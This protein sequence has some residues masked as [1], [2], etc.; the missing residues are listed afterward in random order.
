M[1]HAY[2]ATTRDIQVSVRT[3]FLPDQSKPEEG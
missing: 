3:F 2:S 1:A